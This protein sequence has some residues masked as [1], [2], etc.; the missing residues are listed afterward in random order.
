VSYPF[1]A[2]F[3]PG[4]S[5]SSG[6]RFCIYH[7]AQGTRLKGL[8][9]YVHPL[10][11][12]MNK[13]RRMAALQARA[14][15]QAGFGVLQLDTLG[16]GDSS[17][18]FS[19]ASWDAWIED[20][21]AGATWLQAQGDAPLWFWGLRGG[22]LLAVAAATRRT[23][24]S[25]FIFWQPALNGKTLLQQFLRLKMAAELQSGQA[26]AV[27][28]EMRA[29]LDAGQA[30]E[31]AGYRLSSALAGGLEAAKLVIPP[32]CQRLIWLELSTRSD[33]ALL[34]TSAAVLEAWTQA[35][36]A[37][38]SQVLT[39]P[40]FW[41][42][43]EIEDAPNLVAATLAALHAATTGTSSCPPHP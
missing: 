2:F 3:L 10:F 19:D 26:K 4:P 35:G 28:G 29:C 32:Q 39:G 8:V 38:H 16:C 14:L 24:P 43:T 13:S 20:L 30:V 36:C 17:G 21:L 33:A 27:M 9:L 6:Q 34:P 42:T 12:E 18:D 31:V 41:Q 23:D 1:Q 5:S 11:E 40:A 22:C 37:V 15:A 7:P 25:R